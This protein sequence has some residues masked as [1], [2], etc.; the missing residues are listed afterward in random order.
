MFALELV[1]RR[2]DL[3]LEIA[4]DPHLAQGD[5]NSREIAG[6]IEDIFVL[7]AP[8]QDLFADDDERGRSNETGIWCSH[9]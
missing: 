8:G 9:L 5:V 3:R 7:G 6:D 1:H 2:D 4:Y